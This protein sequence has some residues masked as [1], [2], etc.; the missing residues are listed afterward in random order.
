M[1]LSIETPILQKIDGT[2]GNSE[3]LFSPKQSEAP[4]EIFNILFAAP[5]QLIQDA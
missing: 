4:R 5:L 1:L 2:G 3:Q